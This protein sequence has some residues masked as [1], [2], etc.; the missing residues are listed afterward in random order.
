MREVVLYTYSALD[1]YFSC[2]DHLVIN[3]Y[4]H[5]SIDGV[6]AESHFPH[7]SLRILV[8]N[9]EGV[10]KYDDKNQIYRV[11]FYCQNDDLAIEAIG[12]YILDNIIPRI[13][14]HPSFIQYIKKQQQ[15]AIDLLENLESE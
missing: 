15:E 9:K 14:L 3:E 8:S 13:K 2:T 5:N 6:F 7:S 10:V 11:W 12:H 1:G 4:S